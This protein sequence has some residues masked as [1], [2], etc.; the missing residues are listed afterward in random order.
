[1]QRSEKNHLRYCITLPFKF[2]GRQ[3]C[4]DCIHLCGLGNCISG[5]NLKTMHS[6]LNSLH[7]LLPYALT[8]VDACF[9]GIHHNFSLGA[10]HSQF[11]LIWFSE[12]RCENPFRINFIAVSFCPWKIWLL[13]ENEKKY[14]FLLPNSSEIFSLEVSFSSVHGGIVFFF[15]FLLIYL[16]NFGHSLEIWIFS[17]HGYCSLLKTQFCNIIES[18]QNI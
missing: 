13:F 15:I 9:Y 10:R 4:R 18:D 1:M 14:N 5:L 12:R 11:C 6:Y 7:G 16:K 3:T 17:A 8:S 2:H